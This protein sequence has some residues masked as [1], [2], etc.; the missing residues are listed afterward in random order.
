[1]R[2]VPRRGCSRRRRLGRRE[3][4]ITFFNTLFDENATC[5]I[6]Y[7]AGLAFGVEGLDDLSPAEVRE[8]GV[9]VSAVHTDLMI[10]GPEVDVDGI[11]ADGRVVPILRD[12]VWQLG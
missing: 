7:G 9:N 3:D 1:M 6:A 2:Q 4:G 5:H 11:T 10:G 8:R 12:D